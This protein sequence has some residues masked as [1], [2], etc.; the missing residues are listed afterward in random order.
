[1]KRN[2][3]KKLIVVLVFALVH[4]LFASAMTRSG[5]ILLYLLPTCAIFA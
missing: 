1:M 2:N 3:M 4:S 5:L